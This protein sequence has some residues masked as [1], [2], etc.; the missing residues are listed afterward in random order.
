MLAL[1]PGGA[2]I[3]NASSPTSSNNPD[4]IRPITVN[5][6]GALTLPAFWR[7]TS[8]IADNLASFPRTVRRDGAKASD[9]D[10]APHPLSR[11][12]GRRRKPNA[13]RSG[14]VFWRTLFFHAAHS[15]NGYA[16][17]RRGPANR[18]TAMFNVAPHDV[19]SVTFTREGASE[20]EQWYLLNGRDVVPAAD[21]I[22]IQG[23]S[24]DG[25]AGMDPIRTHSD[26]IS[27]G[28]TIDRYVTKYLQKG[29]NIRGSIEYPSGV[30]D[31]RLAQVRALLSTH[32][33][34]PNADRDI[35][36][37]TDGAKFNNATQLPKDGQIVE[38]AAYTTKQI[39]Q[40]TGV[41]PE[42]LFELSEAKY[43]T[44]VE[45][46]GINVVRYLFRPWIEQIEDELTSKLLTADE[47]DDGLSIALNPEALLRG[48]TKTQ[49]DTIVAKANAGLI[50][51]N[52]G[53]DYLGL[54]PSDN[55]EDDKLHT[56]GSTTA[57]ATASAAA[58]DT[59][60]RK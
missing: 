53:R 59:E 50:S 3:I 38:Q 31:E 8:F 27:R 16:R 33:Y 18:A 20:P 32:F 35:L 6:Y 48:D 55:P 5:A 19:Y 39:A 57:P 9:V 7:A 12:I 47:I 52:E 1:S 2:E 40:I 34:G 43:N 54:P 21:M 26:T 49:T 15:G 11:L 29:T 17:I 24:Y 41:P 44:S 10:D 56:L 28:L 22:H 36:Q 60:P 46:A 58:T 45:Q 13:A 4:V 30:S 51:K 14:F 42:Y 23:I 37:L 25:T